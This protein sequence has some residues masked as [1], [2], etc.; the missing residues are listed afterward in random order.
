MS[1]VKSNEEQ[2]FLDNLDKKLW[3]AADRLRSN[4]DAA[5]YKHA[6]LGLIFLKYVSDSFDLRREELRNQFTDPDS[7]YYLDREDY[8]SDA[9]YETA[10]QEELEDRDYFTEEN[11]FWVPALARW[12]NIKNNATLS[13][14]EKIEI[15]NGKRTPTLFA[16]SVA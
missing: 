2:V 3:N 1:P 11:V 7:D 4:L 6:V 16:Q 5:V 8:D 13:A 12:E 15:K 9:E 14:G 10:I